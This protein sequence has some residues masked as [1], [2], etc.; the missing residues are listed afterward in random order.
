[1]ALVSVLAE[2]VVGSFSPGM[3][4]PYLS[5][6]F[7][8]ALVRWSSSLLLP[9]TLTGRRVS[10]FTLLRDILAGKSVVVTNM[11]L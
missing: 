5:N 11:G 1:M 3:H 6:K 8:F 9:K 7:P 10:H 4:P 2:S